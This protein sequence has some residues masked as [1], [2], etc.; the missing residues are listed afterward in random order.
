[1]ILPPYHKIGL[2]DEL[3]AA[4]GAVVNVT[5]IAGARV[6]P[7]AGAAYATSK[8][9]LAAL[10]REMA[11]DFGPLGVRVIRMNRGGSASTA[12]GAAETANAA[13]GEDAGGASAALQAPPAPLVPK[14]SAR[15]DEGSP[16]R[17]QK[18]QL[19]P[20]ILAP[21]AGGGGAGSGERAA[22]RASPMPLRIHFPGT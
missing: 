9:A 5:S 13:D 4:K 11:H 17:V 7:F 8:A 2:K 19:R 6:H 14:P 3:E 12:A 15:E 10:T 18:P 20:L 21:P 16:L 22:S 1:M